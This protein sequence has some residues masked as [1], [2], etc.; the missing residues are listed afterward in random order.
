M[1]YQY[2]PSPPIYIVIVTAILS[3]P[4]QGCQSDPIGHPWPI[5]SLGQLFLRP[6]LNFQPA[7]NVLI[8]FYDDNSLTSVLNCDV[9]II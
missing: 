7:N 8:G 5:F 9:A 2:Q 6:K 4:Y 3:H 1:Y